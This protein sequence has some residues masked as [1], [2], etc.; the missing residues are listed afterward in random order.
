MDESMGEGGSKARQVAQM[1]KTATSLWGDVRA[2][3][4]S[5]PAI[6]QADYYRLACHLLFE[7]QRCGTCCRT[8]DPIRLLPED[9]QALSRHLKLPLSRASKKYLSRDEKSL[10]FKKVRPCRFFD[11]SVSGCRIYPARPHSCR[12]FPFLGVYGGD[13]RVTLHASCPG[14]VEAVR[15]LRDAMEGLNEE[16]DPEKV[17]AARRWFDQVLA[18]L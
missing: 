10:I 15:S 1:L 8:G 5:V 16:T 17:R 4:L 11:P 12:I 13:E 7:C 14:S 2:E 3:E 18:S 9:A 6:S